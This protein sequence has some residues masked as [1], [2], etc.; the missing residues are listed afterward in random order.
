MSFEFQMAGYGD[1]TLVHC[2][3]NALHMFHAAN[4]SE[5]IQFIYGMTGGRAVYILQN[6]YNY[7]VDNRAALEASDL[8]PASGFGSYH[9]NLYRVLNRLI[10]ISD[11]YPQGVWE[12]T[13]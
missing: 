8:A 9:D 4:P 1:A 7:M 5:G 13:Y 12:I 6:I 3:H 10:T 11:D 2:S